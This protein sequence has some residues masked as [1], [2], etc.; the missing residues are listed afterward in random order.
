MGIEAAIQLGIAILPLI[1]KAG[2]S[3]YDLYEGIKA[4]KTL[5]QLIAEAEAKR[6]DLEDLPFG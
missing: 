2:V 1:E 4:N 6:D 3:I 5:E